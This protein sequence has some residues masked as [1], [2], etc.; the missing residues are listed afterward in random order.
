MK[1]LY[2]NRV[3]LAIG[4]D[5]VTDSSVKEIQ[6]LQRFGVFDNLALLKMWTRNYR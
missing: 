5:D 6:Q 1:L 3:R 2:E 4:S